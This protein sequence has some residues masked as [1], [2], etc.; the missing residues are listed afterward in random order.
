MYNGHNEYVPY[1]KRTKRRK[2]IKECACDIRPL[3]SVTC[4]EVDHSQLRSNGHQRIH[5]GYLQDAERM[6]TGQTA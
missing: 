6:R 5:T 2:T 4:P 1:K 3:N